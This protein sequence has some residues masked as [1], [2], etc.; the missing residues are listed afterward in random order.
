MADFARLVGALAAD[1]DALAGDLQAGALEAEEAIGRATAIRARCRLLRDEA[2]TVDIAATLTKP[3]E[4]IAAL[5]WQ[6]STIRALAGIEGAMVAAAKS[7]DLSRGSFL[8]QQTRHVVREG[9]T[10]Q[11]IAA[12]HHGTWETWSV[13]ATANGLSPATELPVGTTLVVPA[14]DGRKRSGR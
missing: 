7:L 3:T 13:I 2:A 4:I 1:V 5:N 10:F 6:A 11:S 14:V 9:D 12:L 8:A